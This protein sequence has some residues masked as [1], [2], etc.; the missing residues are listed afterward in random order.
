MP[1]KKIVI[2]K[3]LSSNSK[4]VEEDAIVR[5]LSKSFWPKILDISSLPTQFVTSSLDNGLFGDLGVVY[6]DKALFKA[7]VAAGLGTSK[8]YASLKL[9]VYPKILR[10]SLFLRIN[11]SE[12]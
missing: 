2:V 11:Y 8:I 1:T 7:S 5:T 12:K 9:G 4:T 6:G 10:C 3:T